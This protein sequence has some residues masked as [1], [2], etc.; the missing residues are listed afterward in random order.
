M[1]LIQITQP[2]NRPLST[3][4]SECEIRLRLARC[5][6]IREE[7]ERKLRAECEGDIGCLQGYMDAHVSVLEY[8]E[9][10]MKL[11]RMAA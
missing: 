2:A 5:I 4:I 11:E 9:M 7:C 1:T 3:S 8:E 10:L 6:A